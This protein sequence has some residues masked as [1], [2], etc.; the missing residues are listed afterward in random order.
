VHPAASR[1][2]FGRAGLALG[3]AI[4]VGA[5]LGGC[6]VWKDDYDAALRS[7][8]ATRLESATRGRR[9]AELDAQVAALGRAMAARDAKLAEDVTT[10]ADMKRHQDELLALNAELSNRLKSAGQ[11]VSALANEKGTLATAL[12]DMRV[13]L[14]EMKRQQAAA[15]ARAAQFR[16][17]VARFQKMAD[18][19][20][21]KVVLRGGQMLLELPNDVLFDSGKTALK[22]VGRTTLAEVAHVLRGMGDRKFTVAG[23]TDDVKIQSA[24]YPSNWELSTARAVEVVKLLVAEGMSPKNL[25]AAGYGEFSPIAANDSAEGRAKNRRCEIILEPNLDEFIKV[26]GTPDAAPAAPPPPAPAAA[27]K[28]AALAPGKGG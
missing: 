27:P 16:D 18:A 15:E 25:A 24:K 23:H 26:P 22:D 14:D 20:K 11:S 13:R 21:L 8:H 7:L 12:A 10:Q 6:V 5:P 3:L 28:A 9:L 19:G 4:L 17:L 1:P 2:S